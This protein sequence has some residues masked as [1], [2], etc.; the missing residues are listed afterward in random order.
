MVTE[1]GTSSIG[2]VGVKA[3]DGYNKLRNL[4]SA[5][6]VVVLA[7][8]LP[9]IYAQNLKTRECQG[10]FERPDYLDSYATGSVSTW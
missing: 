5:H 9:F 10:G 1:S 6:N 7:D 4:A 2:Y 8:S 3:A